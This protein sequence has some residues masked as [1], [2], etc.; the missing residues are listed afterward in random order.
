MLGVVMA[1]AMRPLFLM[2]GP[3]D[4]DHRDG[5]RVPVVPRARPTGDDDSS[6]TSDARPGRI[7]AAEPTSRTWR[8]RGWDIPWLG[9]RS[10]A[11]W[12]VFAT[13]AILA[14]AVVGQLFAQHRSDRLGWTPKTITATSDTSIVFSFSVFKAPKAV[15]A[16]TILAADQNGGVGSLRDIPIPARA[17]GG[18]NTDLTVTIPTTRRAETAV[19]DS[20]RIVTPG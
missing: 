15:A 1:S 16:C 12:V 2:T 18:Q 19:L 11:P 5:G 7:A 10:T 17:D 4:G 8:E 13:V 9:G 3:R 14:I 6:D 20:C